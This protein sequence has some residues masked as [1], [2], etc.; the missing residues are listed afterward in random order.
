MSV[1]LHG[2]FY[3]IEKQGG[4]FTLNLSRKN[5]CD[6][7]EILGLAD[8]KYLQKLDLSRNQIIEINGLDTLTQLTYLDLSRNR[9]EKLTGFGNFNNLK[10][11][12]LR[13][14]PIFNEARRIFG[15]QSSGNFLNTQ[16]VVK[17][18]GK[19]DGTSFISEESEDSE[20]SAYLYVQQKKYG[21]PKDLQSLKNFGK[22]CFWCIFSILFSILFFLFLFLI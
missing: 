2:E 1:E 6:I 13:G 18:S 19:S 14:N 8:V 4:L 17:F 3:K 20:D 11:L 16:S 5:I 22:Y 12:N 15:V 7:K 10:Y 9:I 21:Q